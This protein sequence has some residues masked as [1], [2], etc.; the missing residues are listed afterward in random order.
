MVFDN[1]VCTQVQMKEEENPIKQSLLSSFNASFT[2]EGVKE[3]S[4]P[5][6]DND[7]MMFSPIARKGR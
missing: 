5:V 1:D 7:L 6:P 4:S 3:C 2:S